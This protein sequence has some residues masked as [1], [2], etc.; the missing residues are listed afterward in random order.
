MVM[1]MN[2][3]DDDEYNGDEHGDGHEG[4]DIGDR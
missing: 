4:S 1:M 2:N 3:G